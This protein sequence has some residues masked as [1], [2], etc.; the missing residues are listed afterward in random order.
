M[1]RPRRKVHGL[2]SGTDA[3]PADILLPAFKGGRDYAIDV[4]VVTPF[5][6]PQ[7]AAAKAPTRSTRTSQGEAVLAGV[8]F[9][10]QPIA[11]EALGGMDGPARYLIDTIAKRVRDH[12]TD[13]AVRAAAKLNLT[14]TISC[15][16]ARYAAELILHRLEPKEHHSWEC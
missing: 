2:L 6:V 5:S 4:T 14:R 11:F 9:K 10:F 16:L 7:K 13:G 12:S 1:L 15:I 3:R 8:P